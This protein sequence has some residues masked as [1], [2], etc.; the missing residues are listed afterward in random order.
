M[1]VCFTK[2]KT[3]PTSKTRHLLYYEGG[4]TSPWTLK[5]LIPLTSN[6]PSCSVATQFWTYDFEGCLQVAWLTPGY[7]MFKWLQP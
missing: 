4:K 6:K 5:R 7:L 2:N 3:P 1:L